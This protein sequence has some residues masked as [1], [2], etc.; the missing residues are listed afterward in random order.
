MGDFFIVLPSNTITE[1][2]PENKSSD[3]EIPLPRP[4][5]F[6]SITYECTLAEIIY[7]HSW[8]N[9]YPPSL[10]VEFGIKRDGRV[11]KKKIESGYYNHIEHLARE[12]DSLKPENFKGRIFVSASSKRVKISLGPEEFIN[13]HP[14]MAALLGFTE[15]EF[16]NHG[17]FEK[18]LIKAKYVADIHAT[19][20]NIYV[21]TNIVKETLVGNNYYNL[22]R[23]VPT[24]GSHG[25][26]IHISFLNPF[27]LEIAQDRICSIRITLCDDLGQPVRFQ[28]GKV[29]CILH[30]RRKQLQLL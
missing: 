18:M 6:G 7:P 12:I 15:H 24:Q 14:D 25:S 19:M 11:Y 22:L 5:D 28:F 4:I 30:F 17:L 27:Y 23:I 8:E 10:Q 1:I 20:H 21:Y 26:I 13:F 16:A 2:F 3:Y 29:V 9:V